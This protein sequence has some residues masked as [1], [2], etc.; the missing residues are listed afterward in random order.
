MAT[1][2]IISSI[3]AILTFIGIIVALGLGVYS[4]REN[5]K[6]LS[7]QF[8][9]KLLNDVLGWTLDFAECGHGLV[10]EYSKSLKNPPKSV[11]DRARAES[12]AIGDLLLAYLKIWYR[13]EYIKEISPLLGGELK[14]LI[15]EIMNQLSKEIDSC[16]K[17]KDRYLEVPEDMMKFKEVENDWIKESKE[18][19]TSTAKAVYALIRGISEVAREYS[20]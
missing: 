14:N 17:Y 9:N 19:T 10:L 7:K 16:E 1:S 12:I 2:D 3:L 13:G 15:N 8:K 20:S 4:F 5:R 11:V 18:L 6:L